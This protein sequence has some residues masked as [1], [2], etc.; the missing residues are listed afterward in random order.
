MAVEDFLE[1]LTTNQAVTQATAKPSGPRASEPV[2]SL[3]DFECPSCKQMV[4]GN[5]G[6]YIEHTASR[7][8]RYGTPVKRLC[9][10]SNN[11]IK[12][13]LRTLTMHGKCDDCDTEFDF[14]LTEEYPGGLKKEA[15]YMEVPCVKCTGLTTA[16]CEHCGDGL[17]KVD[18]TDQKMVGCIVEPGQPARW[19]HNTSQKNECPFDPNA[20]VEDD[21]E[22]LD[23]EFFEAAPKEQTYANPLAGTEHTAPLSMVTVTD[24]FTIAEPDDDNPVSDPQEVS[25]NG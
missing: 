10:R 14:K 7:I 11:P 19:I 8:D 17:T 2:I 12:A 1:A 23:D 9:P 18:A 6:Y 5:K 4:K 3:I 25:E 13:D 21:D 15:G 24:G 22:D 16:T 20:V